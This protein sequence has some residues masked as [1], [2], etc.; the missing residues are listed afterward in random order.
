MRG[1][2]DA[3]AGASARGLVP[4]RRM[5]PLPASRGCRPL[6]PFGHEAD[7][8]QYPGLRGGAGE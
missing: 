1:P 6:C 8:P 2:A 5:L 3:T 7:A 4:G